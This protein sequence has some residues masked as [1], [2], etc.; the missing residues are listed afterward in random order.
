MGVLELLGWHHPRGL[1]VVQGPCTSLGRLRGP[2]AGGK[3]VGCLCFWLS[4]DIRP[5]LLLL[6][7]LPLPTFIEAF[8]IQPT[9]VRFP[10]EQ[11]KGYGE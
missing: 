6:G 9:P 5:F 8:G 1:V 7:H 10:S 4:A 3:A 2:S 11:Q